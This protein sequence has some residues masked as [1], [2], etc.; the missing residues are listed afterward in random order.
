MQA[1][2]PPVDKLLILGKPEPW[3]FWI[4]YSAIGITAEHVPQLIAMM[5]DDQL[6]NTHANSAEVWAPMHAWR[7]LAELRATEAI[8]PMISLLDLI[9]PFD[10]DAIEE[11][12]PVALGRF[13][14]PAIEPLQRYL[15]DGTRGEFARAAA[16]IA[17]RHIGISSHALRPRAVGILIEALDHFAEQSPR[18]NAFLVSQLIELRAVDQIASIERAYAAGRVDEQVCGDFSEIC[19]DLGLKPARPKPVRPDFA[20]G[21]AID[22]V[23]PARRKPLT[24]DWMKEFLK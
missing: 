10:D 19:V 11:D 12:V 8:E 17:V 16:A 13:G 18:L 7:A 5:I 6:N 20:L 14:A 15:A 9:E 21:R 3:E 22:S 1:Y 23:I 2:H 4:S 24:P